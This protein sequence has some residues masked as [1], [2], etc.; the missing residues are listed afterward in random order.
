MLG[1]SKPVVISY[2]N[3]RRSGPPVPRWLI[4]LT[5]GVAAGAGGLWLL[6]E[7]Y[8]PPR[9]TPADSQQLIA[10]FD[11]ADAERKSVKEQLAATAMQLETAQATTRRQN[12]E[13]AA[14]RAEAQ[15]LRDD[16]AAMI[17]ALPADPR[18]GVVQVRGANFVAQGNAL[19][20]DVILTR[21]AKADTQPMTGVM[22]FGVFGLTPRGTETTVALKPVEISLGA[23]GLLR[24]SL[25]L[26]DG[27][28]ARQVTVSVHESVG[29]KAL[30][31]RVMLVR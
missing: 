20:Y 17:G 26:P 1:R 27:M 14:P 31:M 6:Q 8:L 23:H 18:G 19:A 2:N 3:R 5:L 10:A 22:Q 11:Q 30:G 12:Q 16:I 29:S 21:D 24:G 15:K 25:P 7:K 4:V 28:R 9:L 13:L